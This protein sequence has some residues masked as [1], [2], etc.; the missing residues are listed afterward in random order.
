MTL[1]FF[2]FSIFQCLGNE[3]SE[4]KW[5]KTYTSEE[6]KYDW[7]FYFIIFWAC[8][9]FWSCLT[10]MFEHYKIYFLLFEYYSIGRMKNW[11]STG[12][13][14][15]LICMFYVVYTK[16]TTFFIGLECIWKINDLARLTNSSMTTI[17]FQIKK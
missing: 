6:K 2:I 8:I 9:S 10:S 12:L 7:K 16:L 17:K 13:M 4:V 11:I 14:D 3:K 5:W 15:L 1:M